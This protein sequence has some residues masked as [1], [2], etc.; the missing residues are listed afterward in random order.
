MGE[1]IPILPKVIELVSIVLGFAL[2]LLLIGRIL[3]KRKKK[4][5]EKKHRA[6]QEETEQRER[7]KNRMKDE[8]CEGKGKGVDDT[9]EVL[10]EIE[11]EYSHLGIGS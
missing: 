1:H 3:S 4:R 8:L 9:Q 2:L 5:Q 6:S 11:E 10:D 7:D